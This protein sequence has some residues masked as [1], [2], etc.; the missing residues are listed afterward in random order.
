MTHKPNKPPPASPRELIVVVRPEVELRVT[1]KGVES[2]QNFDVRFLNELLRKPG[3]SL[4][5]VFRPSKKLPEHGDHYRRTDND[6]AAPDLSVYFRLLAPDRELKSLA[7]QLLKQPR[8]IETAYI[9]PGAVPPIWQTSLSKEDYPPITSTIGLASMSGAAIMS[10]AEMSVSGLSQGYLD[11][12]PGGIG[13]R[14][15]WDMYTGADGTDVKIVDIEGGW[16]FS[17]KDLQVNQSNLAV[18]TPID[19]PLWERHGTAVLGLIGADMD[20]FGITGICPGAYLQAVSIFGTGPD[21]NAWGRASAIQFA[22]NMLDPGDIILIELQSPG[23]VGF[24]VNGSQIGYIPLEWWEVNLRAI[25]YATSRGVIVVEAGGNGQENLDAPKYAVN[26]P[27]PNGPFTS[28]WQNPFKRDPMNDSGAIIVGAGAPPM[29]TH[30][31]TTEV[32]RSRVVPFSNF[33]A[34]FDAQGWGKHVETCGGLAEVHLGVPGDEDYTML[35]DGTSSAAA[36]VAGA[37][38]CIQGARKGARLSPLTPAEARELLRREGLGSPQQDDD[39]TNSPSSRRIG[40][41]PNL[42]K[43]IPAALAL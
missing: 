37:L 41:R 22:A 18:G 25:Q 4:R 40:S 31:A 24:R 28:L 32:D 13:A 35:F 9:V 16:R 6:D 43:M 21:S 1:D 3:R 30:G 2:L 33:G 17:H 23:P 36:M 20:D 14:A 12:P 27:F 10:G 5:P 29:G 34:A 7:R 15:V 26:P 39:D 42:L 8:I 11:D 38:G 19:E